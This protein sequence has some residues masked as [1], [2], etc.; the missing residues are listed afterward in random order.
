L[1]ELELLQRGATTE[2]AVTGVPALDQDEINDLE[3]APEGEVEATEEAVLDQ[4]T[5]ASTIAELKTEIGTL[6]RLESLCRRCPP[7]WAG[8]EMA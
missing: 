1:R 2:T 6:L 7:E 3:D 8:H 4:A 5:A